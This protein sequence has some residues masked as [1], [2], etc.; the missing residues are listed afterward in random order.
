M[1]KNVYWSSCKIPVILADFNET[2]IFSTYLYFLKILKISNF[3][4]IHTVVAEL[5]QT[6]GQTLRR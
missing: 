3:V 2:L 1:I 4:K 6:D 5:F